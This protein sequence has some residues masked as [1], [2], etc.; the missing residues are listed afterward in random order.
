MQAPFRSEGLAAVIRALIM[1]ASAYVEEQLASINSP[2]NRVDN[3][4]VWKD[5]GL[6][7]LL[8]ERVIKIILFFI[9]I[10]Y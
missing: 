2:V 8:R 1:V 9:L 6:N 10:K 3:W 7:V 5:H 4:Q